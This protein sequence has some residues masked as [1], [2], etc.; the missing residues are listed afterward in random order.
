MSIP[1]HNLL[2]DSGVLS[3]YACQVNYK[4]IHQLKFT[5]Q[6]ESSPFISEAFYQKVFPR[7]T[8]ILLITAITAI[9]WLKLANCLWK[10]SNGLNMGLAFSWYVCVPLTMA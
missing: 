7:F 1:P 3:G 2:S 10:Q 4:S 9:F 6:I 8:S 5:K